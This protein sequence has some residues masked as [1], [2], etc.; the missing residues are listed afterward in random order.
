SSLFRLP[1]LVSRQ[2]PACRLPSIY[3]LSSPVHL[4]PLVSRPSSA[5]RLPSIYRLSSPVH[6]PP[7]VSRP[8]SACLLPLSPVHLP[9]VVSR[10]STACPSPVVSH[11]SPACRLPSIFRLSSLV[12]SHPSPACRLPSVSRLS[13]V[14]RLTSVACRPSHVCRMSHVSCLS[15]VACLTSVVCRLSHVC[16]VLQVTMAA[17]AMQ[18]VTVLSVAVVCAAATPSGLG[19][20]C[21]DNPMT[22]V[23]LVAKQT[24]RSLNG[25]LLLLRDIN[26]AAYESLSSQFRQYAACVGLL[27]T[28]YFR[29]RASQWRVHE[30]VPS[31]RTLH[32]R[33]LGVTHYLQYRLLR[34]LG[35]PNEQLDDSWGI[36][37][38]LY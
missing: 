15:C 21:G 33:N 8:S 9:P 37:E 26:T 22:K 28:G 17:S 25:V 3:R 18:L 20:E 23:L 13:R 27:D 31:S 16:R 11:P 7:V 2:S 4:A 5:C 32:K 24:G 6:L 14:D 19:Q 1:P 12:V 36:M 30:A 10:P 38:R 35:G 29:K 34:A